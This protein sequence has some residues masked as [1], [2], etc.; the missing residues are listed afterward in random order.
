MST[1]L[2]SVRTAMHC[3]S[4]L[5]SSPPAAVLKASKAPVSS[6]PASST[7]VSNTSRVPCLVPGMKAMIGCAGSAGFTWSQEALRVGNHGTV[8]DDVL[9]GERLEPVGGGE[10]EVGTGDVRGEDD[11]V[12]AEAD[13]HD[14]G[15]A[16]R[17]AKLDVASG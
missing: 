3:S 11:A 8:H 13:F 9:G 1:D 14:L 17:R 2:P 10:G 15:H 4:A 7:L 5:S 12:I 6:Q 16:V